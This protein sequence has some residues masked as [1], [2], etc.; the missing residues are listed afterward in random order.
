MKDIFNYYLK[1]TRLIK[2]K[3][4]FYVILVFLL[5][6]VSI[7]FPY[8]E[9][10]LINT[11]T[12]LNV[13]SFIL[14]IT[15]YGILSL[16]S[17]VLSLIINKINVYI[18]NYAINQMMKDS[19]HHMV[20]VSYQSI[21]TK[22]TTVMTQQFLQDSSEIHDFVIQKSISF[23][24]NIILFLL[25]LFIVFK[26]SIVMTLFIL[27]DLI[28]YMS[29]YLYFKN[30]IYVSSKRLKEDQSVYYSYF[31]KIT[32]FVKD[33]RL[34][35]LMKKVHK[36]QH[37]YFKS[38][39]DSTNKNQNI[40]NLEQL[41]T[42][43]INFISQ[44]FIFI[45]GF[46][47]V[48]EGRMSTGFIV[49]I[50][51]YFSSVL[52]YSQSFLSYF[53]NYQNAKYSYER[54][55]K[56]KNVEKIRH[57]SI[58]LNS[59]KTIQC[60]QVGFDFGN[61]CAFSDKRITFTQGNVYCIKGKNGVGKT[62]LIDCLF[63]I[64]GNEYSGRIFINGVDM[65]E[66]DVPYI[67]ES[68]FSISQQ[69]P[70]LIDGTIEDNLCLGKEIDFSILYECLSGFGLMD[71]YVNKKDIL[72]SYNDSL[73]GG[74]KQKI[75]LIRTLLSNKS[76]MVFDEPFTYLDEKSRNYFISVINKIYKDKI[77]IIISHDAM[78]LNSKEIL[79]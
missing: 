5:S 35:S 76:V 40:V 7:T 71:L 18:S 25:V 11:I 69:V 12:Y 73:S 65:K 39:L 64:F 57:G 55:K 43:L 67:V 49:T 70:Y 29:S 38:V 68:Y 79:M 63:G 27:I 58:K 33:I 37:S 1:N 3:I 51:S 44:L 13:S 9:G 46:K 34:N 24:S 74:E 30:R 23:L 77:I 31:Y 36:I 78:D 19:V 2:N 45:Y 17:M 22:D 15:I 61:H 75:S 41:C 4:R 54:V 26:Q 16:L 32:N 42:G 62:T 28:L 59:V 56:W 72:N 47:L 10:E 21:S 6:L 8:C 14:V 53:S 60:E 20:Q 50:S 52:G 66:L 48:L